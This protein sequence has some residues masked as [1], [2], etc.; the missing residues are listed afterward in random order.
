MTIIDFIQQYDTESKCRQLFKTLRDEVGVSCKRCGNQS[1]YWLETRCMYRCKACKAEYSLRSGTMMEYSK[2]SF[3]DWMYTM[4]FM[5][6]SKK[7]VAALEVQKN[8]GC[9]HY[10]STWVMMHK[11]RVSMGQRVDWYALTDYLRAGN[12]SVPVRTKQANE[13]CYLPAEE[14]FKLTARIVEARGQSYLLPDDHPFA[15]EANGRFRLVSFTRQEAHYERWHHPV[16]RK[17][18]GNYVERPWESKQVF[19]D[20]FCGGTTYK[21]LGWFDEDPNN[22]WLGFYRIMA[23][24]MRRNLEG[25]YHFVS[26]RYLPNYMNEFAYF[27]NRRYLGGEKLMRLLTLAASKP[28]HIPHFV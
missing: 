15:N 24:N 2:R 4:A 14:K 12:S 7:P 1:H 21:R 26:D 17:S 23:V 13:E 20:V 28:W 10:K 18:G 3:R 16:I 6:N 19:D 8:L 5:A 11:I 22:K 27:T 25:V 9:R